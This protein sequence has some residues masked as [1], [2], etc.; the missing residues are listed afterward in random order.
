MRFELGAMVKFAAWKR[1]LY[2]SAYWSTYFYSYMDYDALR[3]LKM[4]DAQKK[5]QQAIVQA[6]VDGKFSSTGEFWRCA[7]NY[8]PCLR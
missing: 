7:V 4:E 6:L 3:G 2:L 1:L 5:L 8:G